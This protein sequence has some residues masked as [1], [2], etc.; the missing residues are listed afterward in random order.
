MQGKLYVGNL[1]VRM[2]MGPIST[3]ARSDRQLSWVLMQSEHMYMEQAIDAKMLAQ[4]S[5]EVPGQIDRQSLGS[6]AV[7]GQPA[8]KYFVNYSPTPGAA[9]ESIYQWIGKEGFPL[10]TAD[11][12]G[13]WT[14]EYQNIQVGPQPD[15]LFEIPVGYQKFQMPNMDEMAQMAAKMQEQL[16]QE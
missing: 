2:D 16:G 3:I 10:K 9:V 5:S 1:K 6:E 4:A 13:S 14:V 11:A 15:A 8:E 7:N 12:K